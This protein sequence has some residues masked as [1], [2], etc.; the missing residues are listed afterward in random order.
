MPA[1]AR[2]FTWSL[3]PGAPLTPSAIWS[4]QDPFDQP[5]ALAPAITVTD[6]TQ[7]RHRPL[8]IFSVRSVICC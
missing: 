2:L 7:I 5:L 1:L 3:E 4:A 6:Q 8:V